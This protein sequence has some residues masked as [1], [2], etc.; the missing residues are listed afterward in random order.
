MSIKI[1][2]IGKHGNRTP[3]SYDVYKDIFL[4]SGVEFS[5]DPSNSNFVVVGFK[6]DLY[7]NFDVVRKF[8]LSNPGL[9]IVVLSEEPL[10]DSLWSSGFDS[11]RGVVTKGGE[12]IEY[13]NV[14]HFTSEVFDYSNVP[15]FIT[16]E[17]SYISRY[18]QLFRRNSML[19]KAELRKLW[20]SPRY[21][22]ASI[23]EKRDEDKFHKDFPHLG[24]IAL[25][26][27]RT[28]LAKR[29]FGSECTLIEGKGWVSSETRQK[30]ADW[31]LD[32]LA[33]LDKKCKFVSA[34]EN[35]G[36]YN[37]TTEKIFDAF[38]VLGIPLYMESE[39]VKLADVINPKSYLAFKTR[40]VDEALESI[41]SFSLDNEFLD[42]YKDT[43]DKL[44]SIFSDVE[45]IS[46]ERQ[47]LASRVVNSFE[48]LGLVA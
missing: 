14:N 34:I 46:S 11:A 47:N 35:T 45:L 18:C 24:C 40:S 10:W 23:S 13:F 31:H 5:D 20:E 22:F 15:Y 21:G 2:L 39:G 17:N 28:N 42:A 9:K 19:S 41:S 26:Q 44:A 48:K 16:T 36:Y 12:S 25:N 33:K 27:F 38:A 30:L 7:E 8:L 4:K 43:Q 29:H 32:K 37:Y 3:F 6:V 1:S